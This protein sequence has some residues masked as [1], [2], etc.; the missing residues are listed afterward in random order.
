MGLYQ[1]HWQISRLV[2]SIIFRKS[3]PTD[4]EMQG[5]DLGTLSSKPLSCMAE[6]CAC[7]CVFVY[8][9]VTVCAIVHTRVHVSLCMERGEGGGGGG[10]T[11]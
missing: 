6:I 10:V 9:R 3:T 2:R 1:I 5:T 4:P 11:L 7:V 8:S